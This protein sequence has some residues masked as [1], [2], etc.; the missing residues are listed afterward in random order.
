MYS[1]LSFAA[2][3]RDVAFHPHEHMVSFCAFG[4]NQPI[5]VYIY[6]YKVA[7]QEAELVKDSIGSLTSG[8]LRGPQVLSNSSIS[9]QK[10]SMSPADQ[11]VTVAR[12]SMRMQKVK[13]KLDSVTANSN[14][15]L[16]AP[17]LLSPHSKVRLSS[18]LGT[19]QIPLY[20]HFTNQ[21][22]ESRS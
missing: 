5:L 4:Q 18:T 3:L 16:P 2:P 11:F 21:T 10:E 20:H 19:S 14:L 12:V 9:A 8:T 22:G 1:D 17:S 15:L 7:Q 13:Q 6:D